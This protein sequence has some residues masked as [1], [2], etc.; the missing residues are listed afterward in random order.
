MKCFVFIDGSN[1]YNGSKKLIN[2]RSVSLLKFDYTAFG[3]FL[4][5]EDEF[6]GARYYIGAIKRSSDKKSEILFANQQKL[7]AWLQTH[8][9]PTVLGTII[10]HPDKTYHEKGVDVRIAVEMIRMARL[11]EYD[12][13]ILISSDTDLVPAVEEVRSLDKNVK[14]VGFPNNQSFG[15]TKASDDL[16]VLR[17]EDL[18]RFF[19]SNLFLKKEIHQK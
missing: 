3:K 10:K 2:D 15:L 5:A 17:K 6:A 9:I 13:A 19:T 16:L 18:M 7:I 4:C 12:K 11:N 14:Y 8:N 1:F